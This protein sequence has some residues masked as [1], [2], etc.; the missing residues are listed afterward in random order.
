NT[1]ESSGVYSESFYSFSS[2]GWSPV[3]TINSRSYQYIEAPKPE[4]YDLRAD[5]EEKEN[6]VATQPAVAS[7]LD[8]QLKE[9]VQRYAPSDSSANGGQLDS[10][11][12]EK[13]RALG[14]MA[15][16]SPVSAADLAAGLPDPK[17]KI[18]D[19]NTLL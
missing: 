7:V 5:P 17:D 4:L 9:L 12:V 2:F 19:F 1:A 3:R 15:Y 16:R 11:A 14:Y 10:E 6:L 18:L 13:L 8:K